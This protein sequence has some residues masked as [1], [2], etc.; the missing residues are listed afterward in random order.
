MTVA[1]F[2]PQLLHIVSFGN[3]FSRSGQAWVGAR[4]LKGGQTGDIDVFEKAR[5]GSPV[6][7][8]SLLKL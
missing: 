1:E 7:A 2:A 5:Q 4:Q 6:A 3:R 8:S